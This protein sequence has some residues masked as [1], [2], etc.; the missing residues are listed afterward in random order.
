M[1]PV[2]AGPLATKPY[3]SRIFLADLLYLKSAT[4]IKHDGVPVGF[5]NEP[6]WFME[7]DDC[8][9]QLSADTQSATSRIYRKREDYHFQSLL[10]CTRPLHS[11]NTEKQI[12]FKIAIDHHIPFDGQRMDPMV[13]FVRAGMIHALGKEVSNIGTM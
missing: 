13:Q 1:H 6:G 7:I 4:M 11:H 3:N 10:W 8:L 12:F 2:H 5:G 9:D